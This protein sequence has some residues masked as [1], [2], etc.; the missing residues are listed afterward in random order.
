MRSWVYAVG[1]RWRMTGSAVTPIARAVARS[2]AQLPPTRP[3]CAVASEWSRS[4]PSVVERDLPAVADGAEAHRVGDPH[5]GEEHLVERRAAAHLRDRADLD[6]RQVHR[7]DE[8]RQALVLGDVGVGA[9]DQLAPLGELGARAPH[10]LAVDDPLVAVADGPAGEAG[11]VGA[12][13]GLGEQL[14]AQLLGARGSG[15]RTA[16]RCS[17]SPNAMIVGAIS[18]VVTLCVSWLGRA[19][20]SWRSSSANARAYS[21]G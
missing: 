20:R 5:V 15:R 10:L 12:G 1:Q 9:G 2:C 16:R 7:D 18:R 19:R 6:A 17:S 13:A 4:K 14:A 8:R 3:V 11:E 21:S